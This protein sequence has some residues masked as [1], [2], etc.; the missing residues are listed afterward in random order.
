MPDFCLIVI[1]VFCIANGD[2]RG[3]LES[4]SGQSHFVLKLKDYSIVYEKSDLIFIPD[5]Q[6]LS[7][8]C[9]ELNCIGYHKFCENEFRCIYW[10]STGPKEGM[11]RIEIISRTSVG[12]QAAEA[13]VFVKSESSDL[14]NFSIPLTLLT[15]KSKRLRPPLDNSG[16]P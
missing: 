5:T 16:T 7:S 13:R 6:K 8:A 4:K 1:S 11:E 15:A 10:I 2:A 9:L 12:F 3:V 14:P